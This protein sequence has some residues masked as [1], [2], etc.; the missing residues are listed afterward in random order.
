MA[1]GGGVSEFAGGWPGVSEPLPGAKLVVLSLGVGVQSST[2]A[3]MSARG[4]I[5]PMPDFAMFAD[6]GWE[7]QAVYDYLEWLTPQL[8]FPVIRVQRDGPN[9][10]EWSMMA[11]RGELP[12]SGTPLPP[13]F[14]KNPDGQLPL[15][16]SKEF[17]TRPITKAI[18]AILGLAPGERG[19]T[20]PVVEQ[21]I[22]FSTDEMQRMKI[23]EQK[24]FR[25]RWP[26]IEQKMKRED[27]LT[28]LRDRQYRIPPKSSCVFCPRR[29][30]MA[31]ARMKNDA[32]ADW[33]R[34]VLVD[35]AI[36]PGFAGMEGEAFV[37]RQM[38]PLS[39]IDL[40][41]ADEGINV[42]LM[43]GGCDDVCGV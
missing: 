36:R 33:A 12:R 21:W 5:G 14:T 18:R 32:P 4:D 22:G 42:P 31:W 17:K 24:M 26:L 1:E 9:L 29:D 43:L 23:H 28:W 40:S 2:L 25:N 20:S 3:L 7:P 35:A 27:C 13:W 41:V 16:C 38:V 11:A 10:G 39:E 30:I 37:H 6:T 15:H 19:P 34:A 8:P